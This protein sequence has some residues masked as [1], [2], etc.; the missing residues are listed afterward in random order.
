MDEDIRLIDKYLAGDE[1]AIE[2]IVMKYQRKL[3][4]LAYRMTGNIEDSKDMAQKAFIQAFNN[5][6]GFR[7][8][9]AFY[10]WLYRIALN[11]CLNHLKKKDRQDIELNESISAGTG[12]PLSSVIKKEQSLH[13]RNAIATLPERQKAAI[14]LRTYQ[15]L[16]LKETAEVMD[17]SEGAVKAHFHHGMKKLKDK[18]KD[19]R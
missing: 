2:E 14:T 15:G 3:Y 7:R 18:L 4:A 1:Y 12:T 13:L 5:I 19:V 17:C 11:L 9:S 8:E 10:T 6:K 16:S